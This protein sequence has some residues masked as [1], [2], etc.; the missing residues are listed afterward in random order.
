MSCEGHILP[1]SGGEINLLMQI[2]T[3]FIDFLVEMV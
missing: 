1:L 3:I 2:T